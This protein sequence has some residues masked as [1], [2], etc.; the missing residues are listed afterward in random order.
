MVI[1]LLIIMVY[2][3]IHIPIMFE[4]PLWDHVLPVAHMMIDDIMMN[5]W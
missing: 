5:G 4:L 3:Y 2:I 1:N